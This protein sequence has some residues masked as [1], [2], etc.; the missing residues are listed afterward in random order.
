MKSFKDYAHLYLG[1]DG[2][3]TNDDGIGGVEGDKTKLSYSILSGNY[4]GLQNF[5]PLLRPII[6]STFGKIVYPFNPFCRPF[7]PCGFCPFHR[8]NTSLTKRLLFGPI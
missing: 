6:H 7:L 5:T 2:F 3:L 4:Y 1:C 8:R